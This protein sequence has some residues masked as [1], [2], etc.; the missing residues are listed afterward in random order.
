MNNIDILLV[1]D[2]EGDIRLLKEAFKVGKTKKNLNVVSDGEKALSY[3][4]KEGSYISSSR[5]DLIILDLN[6]P[7]KDGHEVLKAIKQDE[8]L[9]RIPVIILTSSAA[10][11]DIIK[12]YN[13]YAICY[14]I[15]P[16]ALDEVFNLTTKIEE[17]W[18]NFSLL[19]L[20]PHKRIKKHNE[21]QYCKNSSVDKID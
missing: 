14:I 16:Y 17:F 20:P 12:V 8:S 10:N 1:E 11:S 18:F 13:D 4:R 2:N 3:L 5:P 21:Q 9:K 15:K 7:R 19:K 6:L